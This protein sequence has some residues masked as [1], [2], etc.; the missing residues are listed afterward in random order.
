MASPRFFPRL[1]KLRAWFHENH[2]SAFG[3]WVGFYTPRKRISIW[4]NV[5]I[6]KVNRLIEQGRVA[7]A[8]LAAWA[9]RDEKRSGV[10][11]FERKAIKAKRLFKRTRRHGAFSRPSRRTIG[12]SLPT[13]SQALSARK[14]A[15]ADSP[16]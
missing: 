5:N 2:A 1:A 9:L 6:A 7:P 3:L 13:T 14:H 10:Y 16:R 8:G 11:A 15:S 12:E 4:S